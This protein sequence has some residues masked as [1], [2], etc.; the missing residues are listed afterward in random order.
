MTGICGNLSESDA[1][2]E[3]IIMIVTVTSSHI[4]WHCQ[5][6]SSRPAIT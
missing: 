3:L 4:V 6:G 1:D 5:A 2:P